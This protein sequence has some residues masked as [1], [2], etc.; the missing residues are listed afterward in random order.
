MESSQT[1]QELRQRFGEAHQAATALAEGLQALA[2]AESVRSL[3][4]PLCGQRPGR[5]C[6]ITGPVGDHLARW[7]AA[8]RA[9]LITREQLAA[10][11]GT[12]EVIAAHVIVRDENCGLI[13]PKRSSGGAS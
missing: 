12:L 2:T 6:T 9:G 3:P 11:V 5:P 8:E 10:V 4:C 1:L 7:L 13:D